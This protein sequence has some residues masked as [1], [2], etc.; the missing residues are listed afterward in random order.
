MFIC[1]DPHQDPAL[2]NPD[3]E[4]MS[5]TVRHVGAP[6][7]R[8][9]ESPEMLGTDQES[10]LEPAFPQV[11]GHV[12]AIIRQGVDSAVVFTDRQLG[13]VRF[14]QMDGPL[15][16]LVSL[17][18]SNKRRHENLS[19]HDSE[20]MSAHPSSRHAS[21]ADNILASGTLPEPRLTTSCKKSLREE[22]NRDDWLS[23]S[24]GNH[25]WLISND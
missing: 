12:G 18:N 16:N 2:F 24:E 22:P 7:S 17:T 5:R 9:L 20:K 25:H 8:E 23:V 21:W 15:G 1:L 13:P 14:Q 6:T 19:Q 10:L 4:C 11:P 3:R